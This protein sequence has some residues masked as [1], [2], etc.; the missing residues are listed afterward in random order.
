M[1][2]CAVVAF[3][4]LCKVGAKAATDNSV[5]LLLLCVLPVP[6]EYAEQAGDPEKLLHEEGSGQPRILDTQ[7]HANTIADT[8]SDC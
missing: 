5:S 6:A 8:V 3:I 1:S 4:Y 2:I 7:T